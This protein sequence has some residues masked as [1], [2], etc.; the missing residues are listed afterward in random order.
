[1]INEPE[2]KITVTTHENVQYANLGSGHLAE[3]VAA[4]LAAKYAGHYLRTPDGDYIYYNGACDGALP[5]TRDA[6][7]DLVNRVLA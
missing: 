4:Y 3:S 1:M 2:I 7:Q 6:Y 5:S